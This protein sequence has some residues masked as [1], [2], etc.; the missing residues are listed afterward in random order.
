MSLGLEATIGV[1]DA[2]ELLIVDGGAA[3]EDGKLSFADLRY[4][5]DVVR[6]INALVGDMKPAIDEMKDLDRDELVKV[7]QKLLEVV[8][9]AYEAF[10]PA[11]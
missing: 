1:L 8:E 5:P 9:K 7:V 4:I 10:K 3:F 6:A 11:A 2:V